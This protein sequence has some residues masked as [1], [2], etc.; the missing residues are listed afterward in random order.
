VLLLGRSGT[1]TGSLPHLGV[2]GMPVIMKPPVHAAVL[3]IF[4]QTNE[5]FI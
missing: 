3:R 2:G 5:Q 1:S 4:H